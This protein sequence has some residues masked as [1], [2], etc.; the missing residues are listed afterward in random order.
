MQ[1]TTTKFI[2]KKFTLAQETD[3]QNLQCNVEEEDEDN[4]EEF[5]DPQMK[6]MQE[7]I[8]EFLKAQVL[9]N[10]E[11]EEDDEDE[12]EEQEEKPPVKKGKKAKASKQSKAKKTTKEKK[13]DE[14]EE[15]EEGD[16]DNIEPTAE[17]AEPEL[18]PQAH[19][20]VLKADASAQ[21]NFGILEMEEGFALGELVQWEE[22]KKMVQFR[23]FKFMA[24]KQPLKLPNKTKIGIFSESQLQNIIVLEKEALLYA[25]YG[26]TLVLIENKTAIVLDQSPIY[27]KPGDKF[28][29]EYFDKA[30]QKL[31]KDNGLS[32]MIKVL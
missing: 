7:Q 10:L 29:K 1:F 8:F 2:D 28:L 19:L 11:D 13:P 5:K 6:A 31:I 15:S 30:E 16:E 22:T 25:N 3:V 20:K 21:P 12:E 18:I 24:Q 32:L 27:F 17:S 23:R 14:D 9:G 4:D 26:T